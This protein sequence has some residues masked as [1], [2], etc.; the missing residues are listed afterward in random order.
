MFQFGRK[1]EQQP[2]EQKQLAVDY[3]LP[4]TKVNVTGTVVTAKGSTTAATADPQATPAV[5]SVVTRPDYEHPQRLEVAAKV[6]LERQAEIDL[7]SDGRLSS[8]KTSSTNNR[9]DMIKSILGFTAM[10]AEIGAAIGGP[11]GA[12]I[13]GGAALLAAST[14]TEVAE[15]EDAKEENIQEEEPGT[16]EP[17]PSKA[18]PEYSKLDIDPNYAKKNKAEA[19][20]LADLRLAEAHARLAFSAAAGSA[21]NLDVASAQLKATAH[22]LRLIRAELTVSEA[23]YQQWLNKRVTT[24]SVAYDEEIAVSALPTTADGAKDWYM[25]APSDPSIAS[26]HDACTKLRIV[27]TCDISDPSVSEPD[28]STSA[29]DRKPENVYYRALCPAILRVFA[30]TTDASKV[31]LE[32]RSTQRILVALP[33][34]ERKVPMFYGSGK[35]TFSAAFDDTG[36]LTSI[37]SDVTSQAASAAQSLGDLPTALKDAVDAGSELA[38]PFTAAGRAQALQDQ[39]TE[40]TAQAA[41]HPAADPLQNLK[42]QVAQAELQARLKVAGQLASGE[43]SN[44]VIVLGGAAAPSAD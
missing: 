18:K 15:H 37:S 12:G 3:W 8:V 6:W 26:F 16:P 2:D 34:H 44:A 4:L 21:S 25:E 31:E 43:A 9:E 39:E 5:V 23:A 32:E 33:G 24:T 41:V 35:Q 19:K 7:Q 13:G 30:A 17:K 22:C 20:Q 42:N 38:K 27:V 29:S 36:A 1:H 11:V 28:A 14:Y 10:G 40:R